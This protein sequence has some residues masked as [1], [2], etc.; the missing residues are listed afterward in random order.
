MFYYIMQYFI[1]PRP[2]EP[3]KI[4]AIHIQCRRCFLRVKNEAL[5]SV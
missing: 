2:L 4:K 5:S 3:K 1:D